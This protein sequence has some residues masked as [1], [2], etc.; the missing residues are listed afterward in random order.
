MRRVAVVL[1]A[2]LA[3]GCTPEQVVRFVWTAQG[4]DER[5]VNRAVA[6]AWCESGLDPTVVGRR[7]ERGLFQVHPVHD[8]WLADLGLT[9]LHDPVVNAT[10][11]H[12]LWER[13]GRSFRPWTCDR[14]VGR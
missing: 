10:A 5:T 14:H 4:A 12:L 6:I 9:D 3:A 13:S 7:G 2:L 8:R 1:V 11:A